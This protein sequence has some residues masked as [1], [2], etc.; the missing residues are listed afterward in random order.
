MG[1]GLAVG[2]VIVV[3][4][5]APLANCVQSVASLAH[6]I[7]EVTVLPYESDDESVPTSQVAFEHEVTQGGGAHVSASVG[8]SVNIWGFDVR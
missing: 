1:K 5:V 6:G 3:L 8:S 7:K 2:G 4:G